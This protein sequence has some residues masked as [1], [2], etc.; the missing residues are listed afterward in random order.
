MILRFWASKSISNFLRAS[1]IYDVGV[2][3]KKRYASI[4]MFAV[5]FSVLTPL[6]RCPGFISDVYFVIWFV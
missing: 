2:S 6:L 3:G 4:L 1:I 5:L